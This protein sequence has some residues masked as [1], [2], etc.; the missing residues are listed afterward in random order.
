MN[1]DFVKGALED[2]LALGYKAIPYGE[3]ATYIP[4][5]GKADKNAL[6]IAVRTESGDLITA[7]NCRTR[8]SI[9]SISKVISL[10]VALERCGYLAVFDRA[11]MEPSGE[12]FNSIVELDTVSGK[13][14]NPMINSGAIAITDLL[15]DKV[16]FTEMLEISRKLT[17]DTDI[18][19]NEK[20]F[21]SE[22]ANC[23]RNRAIAWLLKS[24]G[25]I[26]GN[27][28]EVIDLYTAMCSLNVTAVS[29][30][31]LGAVLA[32]GGVDPLSGNRILSVETARIVKTLMLTCG[33]YD[34]SGQFAV[35][36]GFPTKSGVGGGLVSVVNKEMGIGIYGP[37]LD[38]KG[39]CIAGSHMLKYL[40]N[41][42]DLHLFNA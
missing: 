17:L 1:L 16:N 12:A 19:L 20:V 4:E 9:Q 23:A 26:K 33:M 21:R 6:G 18:T 34:G 22:M 8:F 42:F 15:L 28:E 27:V 40:S 7:G 30:A 11:G 41:R 5:L 14:Y 2:S 35:D 32:L 37:S 3:V 38:S 39:N 29:L 13:P 36:V 24:K 25:I 10:S 31:N